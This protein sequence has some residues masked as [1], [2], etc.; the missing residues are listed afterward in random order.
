MTLCIAWKDDTNIHFASDSRITFGGSGHADV[1][2]KVLSIPVKIYTA[3]DAMTGHKAL[4]YDHSIGM[5]FAGSTVNAYIVKESIHEVL[6]HLQSTGFTDFSMNGIAKLVS[7]F[8]QHTTRKIC[9]AINGQGLATFFLGGFCP[10]AKSIRVFKFEI[11]SSVF[12][13]ASK[14]NE[15]LMVNGRELIGTGVSTAQQILSQ[16]PSTN[17][18]S[19]LKRVIEDPTVPSVGGNIQYGD[20]ENGDFQVLGVQD[21][22][23]MAG[24]QVHLKLNLRGTELYDGEISSAYDDFQISYSFIRPFGGEIEQ[25]MSRQK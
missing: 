13:I 3:V 20:F 6:Q 14:Y 15:V 25:A 17:M 24:D 5:C 4:I 18:F 22:E 21:Y 16:Q 7:E 1:G 23:I 8:F 11:D 12:P 19:L 2:I 10:S 9:E